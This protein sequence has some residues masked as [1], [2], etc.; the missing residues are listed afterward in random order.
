MTSWRASCNNSLLILRLSTFI[1]FEFNILLVNILTGDPLMI[2]CPMRLRQR[3]RLLNGQNQRGHIIINTGLQVH[4]GTAGLQPCNLHSRV[5]V[6]RWLQAA[7]RRYMLL[8]LVEILIKLDK[9]RFPYHFQLLFFISSQNR[10]GISG[11]ISV[12]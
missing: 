9:S 12:N 4:I 6:V 2:A 1:V 3:H 10:I 11:N 7:S 5:L 8:H